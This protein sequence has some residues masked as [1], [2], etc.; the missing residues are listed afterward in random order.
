MKAFESAFG[1]YA[2]GEIASLLLAAVVSFQLVSQAPAQIVTL[3]DNNSIA[4][5]NTG[6]SA[7][8][9][10]WLVDGQDQLAQQWFWYRVGSLVTT[11]ESPINSIS[12]PTI[13]MPSVR[14]LTTT[15]ANNAFS[16]QVD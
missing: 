12:A 6:T 4:R 13:S 8:M 10:D 16:V 15:Y 9:F 3:T 7:G 11:P 1:R 5:V 2:R 14:Q